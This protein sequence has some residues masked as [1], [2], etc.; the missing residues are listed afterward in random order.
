MSRTCFFFR[1]V[2][3]FDVRS[4]KCTGNSKGSLQQPLPAFTTNSKTLGLTENG[5]DWNFWRWISEF[6]VLNLSDPARLQDSVSVIDF[7][8]STVRRLVCSSFTHT[9]KNFFCVTHDLDT[10]RALTCGQLVT[11]LWTHVARTTGIEQT[12]MKSCHMMQYQVPEHH[13][14]VWIFPFRRCKISAGSQS[15]THD[16]HLENFPVFFVFVPV[17]LQRRLENFYF[18]SMHIKRIIVKLVTAAAL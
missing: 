10:G 14:A 1:M 18:L 6:S 12:T 3:I 2:W 4:Y 7:W 16:T 13:L 15:E 8:C 17:S 9:Q 5:S 11:V